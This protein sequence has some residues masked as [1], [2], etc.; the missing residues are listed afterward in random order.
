MPPGFKYGL[1]I[2]G[3][4]GV[5]KTK[6]VADQ[7]PAAYRKPLSKWWDG[8][9]GQETIVLDDVDPGS[10]EWL[11]RFLKI[12]GDRY[13]FG[14]ESKGGSTVIRPLKFIVTS[15]YSIEEMYTDE[16]TRE[17]LNRRYIVIEKTLGQNIIL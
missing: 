11:R 5:G 8:Y 16:P 9:R 12:W 4:A 10:A 15:Q 13:S 3:A 1:W 7:Y 17:A 14:A 6:A 2:Y